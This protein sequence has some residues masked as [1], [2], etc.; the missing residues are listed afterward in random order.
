MTLEIT[1][2]SLEHRKNDFK[3]TVDAS[4]GRRRR[5]DTTLKIRKQKKEQQL[6]KKRA[7]ALLASTDT[8]SDATLDIQPDTFECSNAAESKPTI[9]DAPRFKAMLVDPSSTEQ[10][11]IEATKG[12]RRILSVEKNIPAQEL[13]DSGVVPYLVRNLSASSAPLVFESAWA[14][15]NIASTE[16][17]K[18]V[19]R[20]GS[21][22]PL[23]Q[24]LIHPD[25]NIREQAAWCLGNIAGEG[26]DFR[27][28]V[29]KESALNSLLMNVANAH[30]MSLLENVVWT[31]SNLCRGSPS[32][33][34]EQTAPVIFPLVQLLDKPISEGAKVDILWALSYLSDGNEQKIELVLS[35]GIASKLSQLLQ[36]ES[37]KVRCK[38]PIVR[39]LG[40]FVSG[41][42]SQTQAVIDSGIVDRLPGLLGSR[43]K[44]IRKESSWLASNIACG[45]HQQI[46]MLMHNTQVLKQLIA[47]AKNDTWEVRKE[48]LWALSHVCTSGTPMHTES[49]VETGGLEPLISVLAVQNIDPSLLVGILDA[50]RKVLDVDEASSFPNK[51][52]RLIDE[53]NGIEYLEELQTHPSE[54]VYEKVVGLIEDYFGV[55]DEGDENLAPELNESGTFGFGLASPKQLFTGFNT[56]MN[57]SSSP[58][59]SFPFGSVSTNTFH[60]AFHPV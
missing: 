34:K 19:V 30:N 58:K 53:W 12:F 51:Y 18:E 55:E 20:A 60:P 9:A 16:C 54:I 24:L 37:L 21:V 1:N 56:T 45:S 28:I 5:A 15:T 26:P 13:V 48:A 57:T 42:D 41:N 29:L 46:A 33:P 10:A 17:T 36:D 2:N 44:T 3:K 38:T 52:G 22:K 32:P 59:E 35:T 11:L 43:S 25:A 6:K 31:I 7:D 23:V 49:L 40:N 47:N 4:E 14:L 50:I 27:D 39:I 8:T